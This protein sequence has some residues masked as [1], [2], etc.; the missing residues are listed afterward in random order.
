MLNLKQSIKM[1]IANIQELKD[2]ILNNNLSRKDIHE[3]IKTTLQVWISKEYN[4]TDLVNMI[5]DFYYKC[6]NV[7]DRPLFLDIPNDK[8]SIKDFGYTVIETNFD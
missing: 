8:I 2:F 5:E 7:K 1:I 4:K 6:P 3:L